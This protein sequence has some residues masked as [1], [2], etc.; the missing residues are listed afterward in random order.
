[1]TQINIRTSKKNEK[2][3][4]TLT[5]KLFS[6]SAENVI[7]R[8]AYTYSLSSGRM[9]NKDEMSSYDS[10]GK[11]YKDNVL[12]PTNQRHIY[13]GILC[14]SYKM[15]F[16]N[17][18]IPKL[19]K[20]HVDHGLQELSGYFES[21]PRD[22]LFDF[23]ATVVPSNIAALDQIE[24]NFASVQYNTDK[25]KNT[26]SSSRPIQI[27][28]G[29]KIDGSQ[30]KYEF[31]S[32]KYPNSHIAIAGNSG[33]GKTQFALELLRQIVVQSN[34]K[35]HFVYLD[36]KGADENDVESFLE[37]T[38]ASF[39]NMPDV[40]FPINPLTIIDR[41]NE[42][43]KNLS[44]GILTDIISSYVKLG[45]KQKQTLRQAITNAVDTTKNDY[46]N[47]SEIF[48]ELEN[49]TDKQDKLYAIL[50]DLS[51][52]KVFDAENTSQ[53]FETNYYFSLSSKLN[54]DVRFTALFLIIYYIYN[55]F[56]NMN[57]ASV[58][59]DSETKEMRYVLLIDEAHNVF[60]VKEYH[61]LL[62]KILREIRSKGVSV[63]LVSQGIKEFDQN[64]FDFSSMCSTAF[65]LDVNDKNS[66]LT[67]KFLGLSDA[68]ISKVAR[69]LEKIETAQAVT[70][71]K[72]VKKGELIQLAQ[73]WQNV[74]PS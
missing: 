60:R 10:R 2:V 31:N 62:E 33:T 67:K 48:V 45:V 65:L 52:Y 36:F 58:D 40:L 42:T 73:L 50:N 66:R 18:L 46:P 64:T 35:V 9:F 29:H 15:S 11:E 23:L 38:N 59:P 57:D 28:V 22:S 19:V 71:I 37:A 70:N 47:F 14:Q 55:S 26:S 74:S 8:V 25:I 16:D 51:R 13:L 3:V 43:N 49:I 7:A 69:N 32:T 34:S 21:H 30:V 4:K 72:E 63:M 24:S 56:M 12:F 68:D 5:R 53:I 20:C 41:T 1:M 61:E 17:P 27:D 6:G 54:K 39:I 44:I